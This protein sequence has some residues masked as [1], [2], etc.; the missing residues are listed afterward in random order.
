[1][2]TGNNPDNRNWY[3]EE[4]SGEI[5]ETTWGGW[6]DAFDNDQRP[7]NFI[8]VFDIMLTYYLNPDAFTDNQLYIPEIRNG[9]PDITG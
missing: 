2:V 4:L 7:V 8:C 1:M 6:S 5:A 3:S 9:I